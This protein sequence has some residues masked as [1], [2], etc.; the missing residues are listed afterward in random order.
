MH[1]SRA[2]KPDRNKIDLSD[3]AVARQWVKQLGRSREDIEAAIEKV[4]DNCE[5]VKKELGVPPDVPAPAQDAG[6]TPRTGP[7][8][9]TRYATQTYCAPLMP[10]RRAAPRARSSRAPMR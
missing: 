5:T 3:D 7:D 9:R 4:G 1:V 10:S 8:L 2:A 6:L